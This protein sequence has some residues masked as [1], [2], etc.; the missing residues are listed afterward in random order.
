MPIF[1]SQLSLRKA[2]VSYFMALDIWQQ[3]IGQF[4]D[5]PAGAQAPARWPPYTPAFSRAVPPPAPNGRYR[6]IR[7]H[8]VKITPFPVAIDSRRHE[9]GASRG[10]ICDAF[11]RRD[12]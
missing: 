10:K 5:E 12:W 3:P 1:A 7:P 8:E 4:I 11:K 9:S 6:N 2:V